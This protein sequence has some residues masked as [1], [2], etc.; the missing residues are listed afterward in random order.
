MKLDLSIVQ[1]LFIKNARWQEGIP[2]LSFWEVDSTGDVLEGNIYERKGFAVLKAEEGQESRNGTRLGGGD[3][4]D[5]GE[6]A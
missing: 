4:T 3:E 5:W 1:G 6:S 2:K